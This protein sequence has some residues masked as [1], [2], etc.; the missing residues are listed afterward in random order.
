MIHTSSSSWNAQRRTDAK[1]LKQA[2]LCQNFLSSYYC[3]PARR[4]CSCIHALLKYRMP[5]VTY[6]E[7]SERTTSEKASAWI[8]DSINL[9]GHVF[10]VVTFGRF[11]ERC[12]RGKSWHCHLVRLLSVFRT[13]ALVHTKEACQ[14][15]QAAY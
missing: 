3:D 2:T 9:L 14:H 7:A 13:H 12:F 6:P 11:G 10:H 8:N 1:T 15:V 4:T 5:G